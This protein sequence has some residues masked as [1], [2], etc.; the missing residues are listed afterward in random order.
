MLDRDVIM[1]NLVN[2]IVAAEFSNLV[3]MR[4]CRVDDRS[5]AVRSLERVNE[6]LTVT[7]HIER[8]LR[9]LVGA[10]LT[11]SYSGSYNISGTDLARLVYHLN[12]DAYYVVE[13]ARNLYADSVEILKHVY[14]YRT[15]VGTKL[16]VVQSTSIVAYARDEAGECVVRVL[17]A[18]DS[19]EYKHESGRSS[20]DFSIVITSDAGGRVMFNGDG[21]RYATFEKGQHV[22]ATRVIPQAVRDVVRYARLG[23]ALSWYLVTDP[24]RS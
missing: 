10:R 11:K 20:N 8:I 21:T 6:S 12:D 1:R 14:E 7:W 18:V 16:S 13:P 23:N 9:M 4:V 15:G 19:T 22:D 2:G 17:G 3:P 24:V 5:V